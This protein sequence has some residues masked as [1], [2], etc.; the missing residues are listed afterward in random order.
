MY[1]ILIADD[2]KIERRGIMMLIK[3]FNL[4]FETAEAENGHEALD[5]IKDNNID[6]LFTDI[7]MPFMDGLE[8]I[9]QAKELRPGI[10][11]I[12]F[13]A[14]SDF[15]YTKRAI[16]NKCDHYM[17]KPIDVDEFLEVMYKVVMELEN[18]RQNLSE[19]NEMIKNIIRFDNNYKFL[20]SSTSS[21]EQK[22]IN[23][24]FE[25]IEKKELGSLS[26]AIE[27]MFEEMQSRNVL[28]M[29]YVKQIIIEIIK[30]LYVYLKND[31]KKNIM[32]FVSKT[33]SC[34]TMDG[35]REFTVKTIDE[36]CDKII[37]ASSDGENK[38]KIIE[39]VLNYIHSDY[40]EDI[41]LEQVAEK[42]SLSPGYFSKVFKKEVGQGFV[43]YLTAYRLERA[44]EKLTEGNMKIID[45]CKS[46][47]IPDLSY[48]CF[49]FRKE[50]GL[51]PDEY[52]KKYR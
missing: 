25:L 46:V 43:K 28:S 3:K 24:I 52:R 5:Y 8:L 13:S 44:K 47:G 2:K 4:P 21:D 6:I 45:I 42:V 23:D 10:K 15:E 16:E 50:T 22:L 33:I 40:M 9:A 49:V 37:A 30:R 26:T 11:S 12:I 35:V 41:S 14:Y 36:I 34:S 51:S 38:N 20:N 19:E 31:D 27:A 1:K 17:L 39:F 29:L 7:R 18:K 48:F 32:E